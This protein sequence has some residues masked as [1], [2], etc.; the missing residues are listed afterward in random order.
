MYQNWRTKSTQSLCPTFNLSDLL[1]Q[2][3]HLVLLYNS[4]TTKNTWYYLVNTTI[5]LVFIICNNKLTH[6]HTHTHTY[7]YI[8]IKFYYKRSY[9]FRCLCAIFRK[10]WYCVCW[11][12]KILK[13][14]KLHK[15]ADRCVVK[16]VMFIKCGSDCVCNSKVCNELI[17]STIIITYTYYM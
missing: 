10:I 11:S 15:T 1:L 7:I 14:L 17:W 16:C 2:F 8:Y 13:L 6:T 9:T 3:L 4:I 12:Y 5:L